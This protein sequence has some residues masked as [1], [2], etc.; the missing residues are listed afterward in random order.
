LCVGGHAFDS[1]AVVV[2]IEQ[3]VGKRSGAVG[4]DLLEPE[5]G[6]LPVVVLGCAGVVAAQRLAAVF[7]E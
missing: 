5:P 4:P 7:S 3:F 6:K 2:A 1:L